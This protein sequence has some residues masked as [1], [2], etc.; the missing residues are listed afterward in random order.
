MLLL[1]AIV[2]LEKVW[3]HGVLLSRLVGV[4]CCALV[5]AVLLKGQ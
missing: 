3:T 5:G 2:A 4:A 1:A